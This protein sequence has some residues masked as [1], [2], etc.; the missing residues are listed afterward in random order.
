[1]QGLLYIAAYNFTQIVNMNSLKFMHI[2]R[3]G[4]NKNLAS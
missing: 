4:L 1:M 3:M 2:K